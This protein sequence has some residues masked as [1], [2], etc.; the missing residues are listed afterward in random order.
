MK[1]FTGTGDIVVL[2]APATT[3]SGQGVLFGTLFGVA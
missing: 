3:V 1:N 2:T